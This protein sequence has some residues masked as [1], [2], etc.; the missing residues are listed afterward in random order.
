MKKAGA[1]VALCVALLF[2]G[3]KPSLATQEH[4]NLTIAPEASTYLAYQ[5]YGPRGRIMFAA[6]KYAGT[7]YQQK[8]WNCSDYTRQVFGEAVSVWMIDWD[9]QQLAY[10]YHPSHRRRGDLAFSDENGRND[11]DGPVTHVAIYAGK[12]NGIPY[13]WHNSSYYGEVVKTPLTWIRRDDG[14]Q[15]Y[16]PRYTRRIRKQVRSA[17]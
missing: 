7:T 11:W 14:K 16:V 17:G 1:L 15:A 12:I 9:D 4:Y 6:R 3:A 5:A 8:S 10:G 13:V 2:V